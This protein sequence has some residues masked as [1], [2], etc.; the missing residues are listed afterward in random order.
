MIVIISDSDSLTVLSIVIIWIGNCKV[1][2]KRKS[3]TW[4]RSGKKN[5]S[6]PTSLVLALCIGFQL[7]C[8]DPSGSV[9]TNGQFVT[10]G[11]CILLALASAVCWLALVALYEL[12]SMI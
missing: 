11:N 1:F 2:V 3:Q 4:K 5:C 9:D 12:V 7:G 8:C 6:N 10:S